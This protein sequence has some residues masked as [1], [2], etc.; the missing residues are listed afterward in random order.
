[1]AIIKLEEIVGFLIGEECVCCQ[2]LGKDEKADLTQKNIIT[3]DVTSNGEELYF[4]DR[5]DKQI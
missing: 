3:S 2:C 4:C 1:M 5:C